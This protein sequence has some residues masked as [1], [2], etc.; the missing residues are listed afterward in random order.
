MRMPSCKTGSTT[1]GELA[2]MHADVPAA[3][4]THP[5]LRVANFAVHSDAKVGQTIGPTATN[6]C[7]VTNG[8]TAALQRCQHPGSL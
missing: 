8:P 4:S 6:F 5:R 7:I 1:E 3:E 2:A